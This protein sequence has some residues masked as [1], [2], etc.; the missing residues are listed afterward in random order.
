MTK[1]TTAD[2][3]DEQTDYIDDWVADITN[4]TDPTAIED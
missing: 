3:T 2:T 4:P 1:T